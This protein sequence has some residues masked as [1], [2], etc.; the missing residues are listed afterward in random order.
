MGVYRR[1]RHQRNHKSDHY[2]ITSDTLYSI[3]D[4]AET[5]NYKQQTANSRSKS[6]K[7]RDTRKT[8][9]KNI[10]A[11]SLLDRSIDN[12]ISLLEKSK[13]NNLNELDLCKYH[14]I[15]NVAES[16]GL[17]TKP[18]YKF[19]LK[20]REREMYLESF[21]KMQELKVTNEENW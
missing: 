21:R 4:H 8:A 5:V 15:I 10:L 19:Q 6:R 3:E 18:K 9:R 1:T 7:S 17:Q 11:Y 16:S 14:D 20:N 12:T 13:K 2:S